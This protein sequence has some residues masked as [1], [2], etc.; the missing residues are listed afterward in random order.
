MKKI[1]VGDYIRAFGDDNQIA[2]VCFTRARGEF[3]KFKHATIP[4][5][6]YKDFIEVIG[7]EKRNPELHE[8][9]CDFYN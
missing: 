1:K 6:S 7:N 2:K 9:T 3:L 5:D 4:L 8:K